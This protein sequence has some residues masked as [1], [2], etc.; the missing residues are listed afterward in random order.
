M[1]KDY[2]PIILRSDCNPW[3]QQSPKETELMYSRFLVYRDL[4]PETDRLR[5]TLEVLN[6]TNDKLSYGALK[7]YAHAFR[8]L[9]RAQAWDRYMAQADRAR[10]I[11]AR[12]KAIDDQRSMA[13][14][15][16][17]KAVEALTIMQPE[18]LTPADVARFA[19]LSYKIEKSIFEEFID[20]VDTST[21]SSGAPVELSSVG[22]WSPGERRRRLE[23]LRDELTRRTTRLANDDEVVA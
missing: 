18:D 5:Q 4:G 8:W 22:S 14:Q 11:K 9:H 13:R 6:A 1:A 7:S 12:R 17:L 15:Q 2:P 19:D 3:E 16:R 10:M 20:D 21:T 23:Q